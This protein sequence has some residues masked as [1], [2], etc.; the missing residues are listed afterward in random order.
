MESRTREKLRQMDER[1][2]RISHLTDVFKMTLEKS[3][4]DSSIQISDIQGRLR[5]LEK[6]TGLRTDS[7]P[8]ARSLPS[9]EAPLRDRDFV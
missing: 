4:A 7:S 5:E 1:Q 9:G 6:Y 8:Q 2:K 3:R